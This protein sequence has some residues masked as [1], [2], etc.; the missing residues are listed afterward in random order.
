M[1]ERVRQVPRESEKADLLRK[2]GFKKIGTPKNLKE[3]IEEHVDFLE[4]M[5]GRRFNR[6]ERRSQAA[7]VKPLVAK[8]SK[9]PSFT[10]EPTTPPVTRVSDEVGQ[11]WEAPGHIDLSSLGFVDNIGWAE[12]KGFL[13]KTNKPET[14]H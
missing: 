1:T 4:T 8:I 14:K 9:E 3:R 13:P 5:A 10:R 7:R 12:K 6:A 2:M 11:D